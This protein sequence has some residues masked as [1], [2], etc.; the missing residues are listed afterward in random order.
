MP[1]SRSNTVLEASARLI[2]KNLAAIIS[3]IN[4]A[5][6]VPSIYPQ[7]VKV[8]FVWEMAGVAP[9]LFQDA[10][11]TTSVMV[12]WVDRCGWSSDP[13][14]RIALGKRDPDTVFRFLVH[15]LQPCIL[16]GLGSGN[17]YLNILSN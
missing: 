1:T 10:K 9:S 4:K 15:E 2:A 5:L 16:R 7:S 11:P 17:Q 3:A 13:P 6:A 12:Y 8:Q 14:R